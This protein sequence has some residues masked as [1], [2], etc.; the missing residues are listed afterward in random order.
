MR[1]RVDV[2]VEGYIL[3]EA[4]DIFEAYKAADK[5]QEDIV[6]YN[7]LTYTSC[8]KIQGA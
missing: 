3:V 4:N 2:K 6:W 7:W 5:H 8:K 1:Y